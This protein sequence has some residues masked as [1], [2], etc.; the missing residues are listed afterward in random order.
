MLLS[1]CNV[2]LGAC[3]ATAGT[4]A[5]SLTYVRACARPGADLARGCGQVIIFDTDFNPQ[6]D[7]QAQVY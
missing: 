3:H 7:L 6:Q 2:K 4:D 5:I 1:V